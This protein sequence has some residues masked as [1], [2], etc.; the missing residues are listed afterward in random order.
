MVGDGQEHVFKSFEV[1]RLFCPK[2]VRCSFAMLVLLLLEYFLF[3]YKGLFHR[4]AF[5]CN[6]Y[7][8]SSFLKFLY[9]FVCSNHHQ[10][11]VIM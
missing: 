4:K 1:F 9:C 3:S 6:R 5:V 11:L 10:C 8:V 2:P 7:S